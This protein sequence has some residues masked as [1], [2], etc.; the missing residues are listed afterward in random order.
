MGLFVGV[1]PARFAFGFDLTCQSLMKSIQKVFREHFRHH[2]LPVSQ[3][4]HAVGHYKR[5]L[6]D[7]EL[8]FEKHNYAIDLNGAKGHAHTL[9]S[10]YHAQPMTIFVREFHDDTDVWVDICYQT[11]FFSIRI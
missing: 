3:I 1:I 7:I 5:P 4:K 6:F 10:G 8:S 9:L 2:R 11:A